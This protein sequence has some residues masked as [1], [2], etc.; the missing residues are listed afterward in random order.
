VLAYTATTTTTAT[1][2]A[3]AT[4][5]TTTTTTSRTDDSADRS[6]GHELTLNHTQHTT[7]HQQT[8]INAV[9]MHLIALVSHTSQHSNVA[10]GQ[11]MSSSLRATECRPSVLIGVVV[12]L[13]AANRRSNCSLTRA[14]DGRIVRCGIISSCQSAATAETVKR[15]WSKF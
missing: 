14:M 11:K 5:T 1:A 13:L 15:F 2:A 4:A 3:A 9:L 7:S 12:C 6:P 10:A 8:I